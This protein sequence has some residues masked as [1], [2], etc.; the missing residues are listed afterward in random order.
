MA[1]DKRFTSFLAPGS[2]F[3]LSFSEFF[4]GDGIYTSRRRIYSPAAYCDYDFRF[5]ICWAV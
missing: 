5:S 2:V 3:A 4:L 1:S